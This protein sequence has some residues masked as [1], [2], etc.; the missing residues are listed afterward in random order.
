MLLV[1]FFDSAPEDYKSEEE[2]NSKLELKD[3]RK[4]RLTLSQINKIRRM[5]D[6]RTIEH[7]KER[8]RVTQQ[9]GSP[10]EAEAE[11]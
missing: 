8:D 10:A 9:Y 11:F 6:L 4:T 7:E 1:E 2:D 3:T 5:N